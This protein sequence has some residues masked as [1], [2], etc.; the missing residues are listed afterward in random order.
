MA[1]RQLTPKQ[2]KFADEYIIT[3]NAEESAR[4]AGYSARGNTSFV[5]LLV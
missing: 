4:Q 1:K 2:K 3:G 5:L